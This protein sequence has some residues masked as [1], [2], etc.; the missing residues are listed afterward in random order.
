MK[1]GTLG[2]LSV[3]I[4]F[5]LMC[6]S[7]AT[8]SVKLVK[9]YTMLTD[10]K[11]AF[12][13]MHSSYDPKLLTKARMWLMPAYEFKDDIMIEGKKADTPIIYSIKPGIYRID[14]ITADPKS[15]LGSLFGRGGLYAYEKPYCTKF[16]FE[17]KTGQIVYLGD[18][19]YDKELTYS[20]DLNKM[21]DEVSKLQPAAEGFD[22]IGY[23]RPTPTWF[24][25]KI[26]K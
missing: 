17:V 20:Y 3:A 10:S 16:F 15:G 19:H 13:V 23:Y 25:Q 18:F 26:T 22:W 1:S 7:C 4:V 2:L 12:V 9:D 24:V 21:K 14:V 5:S 11:K 8:S 6:F